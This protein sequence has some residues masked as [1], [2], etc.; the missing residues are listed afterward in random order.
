[1]DYQSEI[2]RVFNNFL[3]YF[4]GTLPS[5]SPNFIKEVFIRDI[6]FYSEGMFVRWDWSRELERDFGDDELMKLMF[7]NQS[8]VSCGF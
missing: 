2:Y 8:F 3:S 7:R 4:C 5:D 6:T 1:M